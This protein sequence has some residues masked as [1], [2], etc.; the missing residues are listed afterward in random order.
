MSEQL[1]AVERAVLIR[2]VEAT[3]PLGQRRI[4]LDVLKAKQA[5][6]RAVGA[7]TPGTGLGDRWARPDLD[8]SFEEIRA[9]RHEIGT[10]WERTLDDLL[11]GGPCCVG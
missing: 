6:V 9:L 1:S 5:H 4:T 10:E 11:V 3:L 2:R 7:F 8:L